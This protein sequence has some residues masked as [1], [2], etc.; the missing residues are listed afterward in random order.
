MKKDGGHDPFWSDGV[1]MNLV[2][3]YIIF[4]KLEIEKRMSES[5]YLQ[6]YYR[7]TPPETDSNYMAQP[8]RIRLQAAETLKQFEQ[9]EN[10]KLPKRKIQSWIKSL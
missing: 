3:N 5:E 1:N 2:W 7:E 9:D 8:D 4:Y 6:I 10:L